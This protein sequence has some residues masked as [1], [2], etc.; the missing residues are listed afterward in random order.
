MT[1]MAIVAKAAPVTTQIDSRLSAGFDMF[2]IQLLDVNFAPEEAYKILSAYGSQIDIRNIHTPLSAD[3]S[4]ITLSDV[5]FNAKSR[6][7][8]YNTCELAAQFAVG[9]DVGVVIHNDIPGNYLETHSEFA[10]HL[11]EVL[12]KVFAYAGVKIE[13]ENTTTISSYKGRMVFRSGTEPFDTPQV[14]RY[15]RDAFGADR[16]GFVF[17]IGHYAIMRKLIRFFTDS[18][19]R[20]YVHNPTLEELWTYSEDVLDVIHLSSIQGFGYGVDH[21]KPFYEWEPRDREFV[22]RVLKLY[23]GTAKKP[24]F[25]VEVKES[26]YDN[27]WNLEHTT[28]TIETVLNDMHP[29]S[30][31]GDISEVERVLI[32]PDPDSNKGTHYHAIEAKSVV[33]ED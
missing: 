12:K 8:F 9:H 13:I 10:Y 15:L 17:D 20:E 16:F 22:R 7:A 25:V 19:L 4:D 28:N 32:Y 26:N 3:G 30:L 23:E 5:M 6:T 11:A 21:G 18:C 29:D 1:D 31:L 24:V 14:V 33:I 2:E 27:C